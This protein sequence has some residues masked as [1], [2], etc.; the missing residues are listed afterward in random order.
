M[1]IK[2]FKKDEPTFDTSRLMA[3]DAWRVYVTDY[4]ATSPTTGVPIN[5]VRSPI[6]RRNIRNINADG[7]TYNA[8]IDDPATSLFTRQFD[9]V[10][11]K[12]ALEFKIA[13]EDMKLHFTVQ[14]SESWS[15]P[16]G[17][18]TGGQ[19]EVEESEGSQH[20]HAD[21]VQDRFVRINDAMKGASKENVESRNEAFGG[22]VK[23]GVSGNGGEEMDTA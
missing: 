2:V 22:V 7:T 9:L 18:R 21:G 10:R 17:A 14:C 11:A 16:N 13:V 20:H 8:S 3:E 12:E 23:R 19:M 6:L 5:E 1:T 15:Q 4:L